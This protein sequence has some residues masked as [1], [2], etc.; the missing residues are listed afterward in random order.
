MS[1]SQVC[2]VLSRCGVVGPCL[3]QS[4]APALEVCLASHPLRPLLYL[5]ASSYEGEELA[6]KLHR[7]STL[8]YQREGRFVSLQAATLL[9]H[10][11][12]QRPLQ[13]LTYSDGATLFVHQ[14]EALATAQR[15]QLWQALRHDPLL[16]SGR[17]WLLACSQQLDLEHAE[18]SIAS[19]FFGRILSLPPLYQR[20]PDIDAIL[21]DFT[22][23]WLK[24]HKL[25]QFQGFSLEAIA[26]IHRAVLQTKQQTP[27]LLAFLEQLLH[28]ASQQ[29]IPTHEGHIVAW[30]TVRAL[31]DAWG[32]RMIGGD[33]QVQDI[34]QYDFQERLFAAALEYAAWKSPFSR[35]LLELQTTLLR[36]VIDELPPH[37]RNYQGVTAHL[38]HLLWLSMK[39]LSGART[40]AELRDFFGFGSEGKIPKATAKL[41]FDQYQLDQ[42]GF[43]PN[44]PLPWNDADAPGLHVRP[45]L[46]AQND[47]PLSDSQPH[48][49]AISSPSSPHFAALPSEASNASTRTDRFAKMDHPIDKNVETSALID[50]FAKTDHSINQNAETSA[51]TTPTPEQTTPDSRSRFDISGEIEETLFLLHQDLLT[52][53]AAD[54]LTLEQIATLLGESVPQTLATLEQLIDYGLL[55]QN[56]L[57]YAPPTHDLYYMHKHSKLRFMEEN[58]SRRLGAAF[59]AGDNAI[60]ENHFLRL[61]DSGLPHLRKQ[62]LD[63]FVFQ[64]LLPRA[65]TQEIFPEDRPYTKRIY[66]LVLLGTNRLNTDIHSRTPLQQR[67]LYYFREACLQ[68]A[69]QRHKDQAICLQ[70]TL[71]LDP[72]TAPLCIQDLQGL[73]KQTRQYLPQ[74]RGNKPNFNLT[75]CFTEVPLSFQKPA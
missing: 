24:R 42:F 53:L 44:D 65:D 51:L 27:P 16:L 49:P 4:L 67:V 12:E 11:Q 66:A 73:R 52:V 2:E 46:F 62:L 54:A 22:Q 36:K 40:Q 17:I 19:D 59:Q 71:M 37:Q 74:G 31:E 47:F 1:L 6:Q 35:E 32:Y 39:L 23:Q 55:E 70:A 14:L 9:Q 3:Q 8:L 15:S 20:G 41:K 50:Q 45:L 75:Y 21:C 29:Q 43:R 58:L 68:R 30:T 38:D 56:D 60:L 72:H 69:D 48:L 33:S 18:H 25:K 26:H 61:P 57:R 64:K 28:K 5:S 13:Q 7:A 10:L 63:P 34:Q